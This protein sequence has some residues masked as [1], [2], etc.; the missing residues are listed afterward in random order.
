M[1][2]TGVCSGSS[3]WTDS[4]LMNNMLLLPSYN[5]VL[6]WCLDTSLPVSGMLPDYDSFEA[7]LQILRLSTAARH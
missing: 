4:A 3:S 7:C 1:F 5:F 6:I 2:V